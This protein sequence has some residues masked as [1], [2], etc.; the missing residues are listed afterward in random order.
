MGSTAMSSILGCLLGCE[1]RRK[2]GLGRPLSLSLPRRWLSPA[3][4]CAPVICS[5]THAHVETRSVWST[6][7][8]KTAR[9]FLFIRSGDR[10]HA[11]RCSFLIEKLFD[12]LTLGGRRKSALLD[13]EASVSPVSSWAFDMITHRSR[14]ASSTPS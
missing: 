8:G 1:G 12:G 11:V 9:L 13:S 3:S 10:S 14:V 5:G 4:P 6:S 2:S 7:I